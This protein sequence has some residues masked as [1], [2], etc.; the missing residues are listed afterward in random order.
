MDD[1][2]PRSNQLKPLSENLGRKPEKDKGGRGESEGP[3]QRKSQLSFECDNK[4]SCCREGGELI[5]SE[6]D[7]VI[8]VRFV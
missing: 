5:Y 3:D 2:H 1:F 4:G 6:A 7:V 8:V